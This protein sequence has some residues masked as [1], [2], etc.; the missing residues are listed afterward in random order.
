[1]QI[2]PF[3]PT[4]AGLVDA[5]LRSLWGHDPEMLDQYSF[6]HRDWPKS[7]DLIRRTLVAVETSEIA[8]AGT[9]FENTI[10]PRWL[11][12][13]VNVAPRWQRRGIGS[14]LYDA[15]QRYGDGRP[16]HVKATLRDAAGMRFLARRG[17]HPVISTLSGTLDPRRESVRAWMNSLPVEVAGYRVV[18]FGDPACLATL[19][20]VA[21]ILFAVY[22][23]FHAWNPPVDLSRERKGALFCGDDV[24]PG[25]I[26]CVFAGEHLVGAANLFAEPALDHP[27]MARLSNLG[28]IDVEQQHADALTAALIRRSLEFA[29]DHGLAVRFE[30]DDTYRPHRQIFEQTPADDVDRDFVIMANV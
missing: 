5:I 19:D 23:Q 10:H 27:H 22:R 30:T 2:R 6:M 3:N 26:F 8:G 28:V 4:D 14:A 20:D 29:V 16:W 9:L 1:M 25:S 15:L 24:V 18:P 17:F 12:V 13:A 21:D 11:L 7:G